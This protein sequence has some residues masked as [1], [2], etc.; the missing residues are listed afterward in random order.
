MNISDILMDQIL[1]KEG[2]VFEN[3]KHRSVE[4]FGLI[5]M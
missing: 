4:E 1:T 3:R 2:K 5:K